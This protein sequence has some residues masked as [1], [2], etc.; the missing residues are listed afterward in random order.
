M[1][2][3]MRVASDVAARHRHNTQMT[4]WTG[5]DERSGEQR[6][7][8]IEVSPVKNED[9]ARREAEAGDSL[10]ARGQ[11]DLQGCYVEKPC[12]KKT[13][14]NNSPP[15]KK[16]EDCGL[17]PALLADTQQGCGQSAYGDA[18]HTDSTHILGP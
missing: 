15:S 8:R 16:K 3:H 4:G 7:K 18:W 5:H 12:L 11:P 10:R 13:Q 2:Q 14:P 17:S 1:P 6:D 9:L